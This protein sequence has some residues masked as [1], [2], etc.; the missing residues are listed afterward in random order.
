MKGEN[1]MTHRS[2]AQGLVAFENFGMTI[3]DAELGKLLKQYI[4]ESNDQGWDGFLPMDQATIG[5]FL[6][7]VQLYC[8]QVQKASPS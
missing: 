4:S 7:D 5:R 3:T 2:Y 1:V 8:E 6:V